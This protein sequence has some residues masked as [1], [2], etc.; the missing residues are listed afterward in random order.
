MNR[1]QIFSSSLYTK[2]IVAF[3]L[4]TLLLLAAVSA[5]GQRLTVQRLA[6]LPF[7]G[8][9]LSSAGGPGG[10]QKSLPALC[11]DENAAGPKGQGFEA[12][13]MVQSVSVKVTLKD[14][15]VA[16]A[17]NLSDAVSGK[18]LQVS[19]SYFGA[20]RSAE[21]S[22]ALTDQIQTAEI[23]DA[24]EGL[25]VL[26]NQGLLASAPGG[27]ILSQKTWDA[28]VASSNP[29]SK[30]W[31]LR[32]EVFKSS[33]EDLS[34]LF[35]N[36]PSWHPAR[37]RVAT[38]QAIFDKYWHGEAIESKSV[39]P[40]EN[41]APLVKSAVRYGGEARRLGAKG[42][43]SYV[44]WLITLENNYY[45]VF[46]SFG[47]PI[48]CVQRIVDLE[49]SKAGNLSRPLIDFVPPGIQSVQLIPWNMTPSD[50]EALEASLRVARLGPSPRPVQIG[51]IPKASNV[52][53]V[54]FAMEHGAYTRRM[55]PN[56]QPVGERWRSECTI[57][58]GRQET[59]LIAEMT[60]R[61]S[62]D[63]FI[64]AFKA[65]GRVKYKNIAERLSRTFRVLHK[66]HGIAPQEVRLE[67]MGC[68]YILIP[69]RLDAQ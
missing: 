35:D 61:G 22:I 11:Y 67:L 53:G 57:A 7:K 55:F 43:D 38:R 34:R 24:P 25:L 32:S 19:G 13:Y 47:V 4:S 49:N 21:V 69:Q 5:Q 18:L 33:Y 60:S 62:L 39:T 26:E 63:A 31:A 52:S 28:V 30:L 9:T 27:S 3:L 20:R 45:R 2:S 68:R 6:V 12:V 36:L 10:P 64:E 17:R 41:L 44:A 14:G 8:F 48:A 15:T 16:P 37:A 1:N 42:S 46:D 66:Q 54:D 23:G 59:T 29:Q 58:I 56:A 40:L 65:E 50:V 51:I